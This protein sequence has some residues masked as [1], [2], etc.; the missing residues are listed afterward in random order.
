[1]IDIK[2]GADWH[3]FSVAIDNMAKRVRIGVD[4][5]WRKI[6][7]DLVEEL[8]ADTLRKKTGR[9]YRIKGKSH[10]ASA[11]GETPARLSGAYSKSAGYTVRGNELE[12]GVSVPYGEYL[13]YGTKNKGGGM[14]MWPRP[15]LNNTMEKQQ[16]QFAETMEEAIRRV[17]L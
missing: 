11:P 14:R 10:Q 8:R 17:L 3:R 15:G 9:L 4:D 1:M 12:F 7:N 6:G 5:G 13:E 2:S 16:D